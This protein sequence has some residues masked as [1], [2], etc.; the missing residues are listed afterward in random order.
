MRR[1][2]VVGGRLRVVLGVRLRVQ[3]LVVRLLVVRLRVQLGVVQLRVV[4]AAFGVGSQVFR[5]FGFVVEFEHLSGLGG[6]RVQLGASHR[7]VGLLHHHPLRQVS[8]VRGLI[9]HLRLAVT[10]HRQ[11]RRDLGG[12]VA[13]DGEGQGVQLDVRR[14]GTGVEVGELV[15]DITRHGG[16]GVDGDGGAFD[17]DDFRRLVGGGGART[18]AGALSVRAQFL[19][20][21]GFLGRLRVLRFRA[22]RLSGFGAGAQSQRRLRVLSVRRVGG[23]GSSGEQN[24][25]GGELHL[26]LL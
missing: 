24:G 16:F 1:Q 17:G 21:P 15:D 3:L 11:H 7:D 23:E 18:G 4:V 26:V 9:L 19:G 14:V 10:V 25:N 5:G 12:G 6:E 8:V 13:D 20:R 22:Q 2:L